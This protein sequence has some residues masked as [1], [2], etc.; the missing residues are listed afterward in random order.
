[1]L[2]AALLGVIWALE[3]GA[4]GGAAYRKIK[5]LVWLSAY[6]FVSDV[7]IALG[8]YLWLGSPKPW[9]GW[10]LSW[11]L[12]ELAL[13]MGWPLVL[14][15]TT[16]RLSPSRWGLF[17]WRCSGGMAV[18]ALGA[19]R[20]FWPDSRASIQWVLLGVEVLATVGAILGLVR[21]W[22]RPRL[23]LALR[24]VGCLVV[25]EAVI[26]IFGPWRG[27]M[28]ETWPILAR[29]PYVLGFAAFAGVLWRGDRDEDGL[30]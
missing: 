9:V 10:P 21:A 25:I 12:V 28:F 11:Y 22:R 6:A 20:W 26:I 23:G 16:L 3:L 17:L 15:W 18:G 30:S 4:L 14:S 13:V 24:A 5:P 19:V 7:A 27:N 2:P 8:R 29:V 1:M